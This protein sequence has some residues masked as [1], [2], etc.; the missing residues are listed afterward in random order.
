MG[1]Q[2]S[3]R[4]PSV[5]TIIA[6]QR[7]QET[8]IGDS[9]FLPN[10]SGIKDEA[11][12]TSPV[13]IT[14]GGIS[15]ET[16]PVFASLSG[17]F[18]PSSVSGAFAT[19][20]LLTSL[21]GAHAVTSGATVLN[22]SNILS[23][24]GITVGISG[25]S[26]QNA[27]DIISLSGV[28]VG[29][30]GASIAT[31][32]NLTS[33]SGVVVGISGATIATNINLTSLS[34]VHVGTS[35]VVT[36]NRTELA[37]LSGAVL[38]ISGAALTAE[39]DPIFAGLSGVFLPANTSGA[40][41][42]ASTSGAFMNASVSGAFLPANVSGAFLPTAVSGAFLISGS[43]ISMLENDVGYSTE[44]GS[45][46][47]T[48]EFI[49]YPQ[50]NPADDGPLGYF[51]TVN[52]VDTEAVEFTFHIPHDFSSLI[53]CLVVCIPDATETINWTT[54]AEWGAIGEDYATNVN[55]NVSDSKSVTEDHLT[56]LSISGALTTADVGDPIEANEWCAVRFT[57]ETTQIRLIGLRFRYS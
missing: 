50:D 37:D 27:A 51:E 7:P 13:D 38:G 16:D 15:S 57:A 34:G 11:K 32:T 14:G 21:S 53:D 20:V 48:K 8:P 36:L 6:R 17:V 4:P 12:K 52:L 22:Q 56:E 3:G 44:G 24:S 2:G 31:N 19:D 29:I 1:G 39:T 5:E 43:Y 47:A 33:L 35:G 49:V 28:A 23:L 45:G 55:L 26:T 9:L 30:S 40:F 25:A 10:Y 54:D 18:L 46:S 42:Q 41:M